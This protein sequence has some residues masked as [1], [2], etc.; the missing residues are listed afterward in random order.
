MRRA[1]WHAE[2]NSWDPAR[3]VFLDETWPHTAL[4][5]LYGWGPKGQRVIGSAPAGHWNTTT[6]L[7]AL[8][9]DGFTAPLVIDGPL[10][11]VL[12]CAYVEQHLAPTLQR[13]DRGILDNLSAHKVAGI[14]AA[15]EARGA[16]LVY[17]PPYSPDFNPIENAFAKLKARLRQAE[18]RTVEG[19]WARIG[20][21]LGHFSATECRHYFRHGGYAATPA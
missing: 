1:Q 9:Q 15:V 14:Q 8:R 5:R 19:L 7:S 13:G 21:V 10:D 11:G 4:T 12:F 17:W 3:L 2:R 20:E 16:Q 18:E 6:F